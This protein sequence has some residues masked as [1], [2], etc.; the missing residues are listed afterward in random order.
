MALIKCPE[1]GAMISNKAQSC[2]KCGCPLQEV[3]G[4]AL[5]DTIYCRVF[6]IGEA[7]YDEQT[8]TYYYDD[9]DTLYCRAGRLMEQDEE[10]YYR[11]SVI[12]EGYDGCWRSIRTAVNVIVIESFIVK[13]GEIPPTKDA[14]MLIA[15]D[16][17]YFLL[18]EPY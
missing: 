16:P 18:D 10:A 5:F 14:P 7:E 15:D 1:C 17:D 13:A 12:Q 2:V 8:D 4:V 3:L 6:P 9:E 11:E